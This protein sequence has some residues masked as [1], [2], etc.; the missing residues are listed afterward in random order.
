MMTI[1]QNFLLSDHPNNSISN[2]SNSEDNSSNSSLARFCHECG[3]P[4][5]GTHVRFCSACGVKRLYLF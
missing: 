2:S 4:F 3:T 5:Q 1:N